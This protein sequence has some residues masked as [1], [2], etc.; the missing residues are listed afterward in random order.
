MEKCYIRAELHPTF[1]KQHN[2]KKKKK[3]FFDCRT[4]MVVLRP[5][6][7][8]S[9]GVNAQKGTEMHIHAVMRKKKSVLPSTLSLIV[10][11]TIPH[12]IMN[13]SKK[14]NLSFSYDIPSGAFNTRKRR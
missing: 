14:R 5:T 7:S 12:K 10:H 4:L 6:P 3:H 9:C 13:I 11:I 2:V 8:V 1:V